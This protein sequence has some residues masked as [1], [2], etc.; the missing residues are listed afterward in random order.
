MSTTETRRRGGRP[1]LL[2]RQRHDTIVASILAGNYEEVSAQAAGVHPATFYR[3]MARGDTALPDPLPDDYNP[4]NDPDHIYREFRDD[5]K[6]AR[7]QAEQRNILI[8]QRAAP[9]TWQA[10]A[11]WLERSYPA[12]YGRRTVLEHTGPEGGPIQVRTL[13]DIDREIEEA[14]AEM[15]ARHG[16]AEAAVE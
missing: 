12:R 2:D 13:S 9:T 16:P 5:V 15:T 10:A 8:I 1:T 14:L 11:W 3:W 6:Q 7:A 4:D